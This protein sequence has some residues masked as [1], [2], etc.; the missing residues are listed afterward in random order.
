MSSPCNIF[1]VDVVFKHK[2]YLLDLGISW[3]IHLFIQFC[4]T[5]RLSDFSARS[6][7][8]NEGERESER[9]IFRCWTVL[10]FTITQECSCMFTNNAMIVKDKMEQKIMCLN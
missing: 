10:P 4:W 7:K 1:L 5:K 2:K 9:V 6:Q 3:H 8:I